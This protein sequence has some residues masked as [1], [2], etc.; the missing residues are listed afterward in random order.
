MSESSLTRAKMKTVT[1]IKIDMEKF[2]GRNNFGLWQ[3]EK[4]L[5]N[6]Y[7]RK[8]NEKR[9]YLKKRLF[10]LQL[11]SDTTIGNHIDNHIDTFNQF[12]ADLSNLDEIFKDEDKVILLIRSFPNKL[13][14]LCIT[15]LYEKEKLSFDEVSAILY[16]HEIRK[17]DQKENR[18]IPTETLT[19]RGHSQSHKQEKKGRSRLK[20]RPGK[21]ECAFC[22]EKGH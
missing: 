20:G 17:K 19:T 3:Y 22:H 11:K 10:C 16:N 4:A 15:L 9:L 5:E 18:D 21:D 13:D 12:I 7:M 8:S 14:H 6:K 1:N 2:D